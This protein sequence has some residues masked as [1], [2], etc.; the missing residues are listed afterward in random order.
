[1]HPRA[2]QCGKHGTSAFGGKKPESRSIRR[3]LYLLTIAVLLRQ[4]PSLN[5]KIYVWTIQSR[6]DWHLYKRAF[7]FLLSLFTVPYYSFPDL[8]FF[9]FPFFF[10][11]G[12]GQDLAVSV[13]FS[14]STRRR[15]AR[16]K[17]QGQ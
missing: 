1:M 13:N 11:T 7:P 4:R 17:S 14:T 6:L 9:F 15:Q 16:V 3:I 2:R 10:T 12:P 5:P 8:S